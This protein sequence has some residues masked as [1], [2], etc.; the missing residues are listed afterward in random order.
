[1]VSRIFCLLE[2]T[3]FK[4]RSLSKIKWHSRKTEV[5]ECQGMTASLWA[6][7]QDEV[8]HKG[9]ALTFLTYPDAVSS[10]A[11]PGLAFPIMWHP[12][13]PGSSAVLR[14]KA[15]ET[16]SLEEKRKELLT[17]RHISKSSREQIFLQTQG[18][19][20]SGKGGGNRGISTAPV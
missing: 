1:M 15:G 11:S 6:G 14:A 19:Q 17:S 10:L 3:H 13:V 20:Q 2:F 18:N 5:K 7:L 9:M 4:M 12:P 8:A 16:G